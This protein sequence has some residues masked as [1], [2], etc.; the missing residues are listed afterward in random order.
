MGGAGQGQIPANE[1][2]RIGEMV[3]IGAGGFVQLHPCGP[4]GC[5]VCLEGPFRFREG[6]R[7]EVR[8]QQARRFGQPYGGF[9]QIDLVRTR[10]CTYM[11]L[12]KRHDT[13]MHSQGSEL[14]VRQAEFRALLSGL[15]FHCADNLQSHLPEFIKDRT[16]PVN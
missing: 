4:D 12:R 5:D 13:I 8:R 11:I 6:V 3:P 2:L 15:P 9:V 7:N 14:V 10:R 1:T 16:I